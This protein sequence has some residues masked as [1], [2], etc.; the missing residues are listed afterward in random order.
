M[1][2]MWTRMPSTQILMP[3]TTI[4]TMILTLQ[5]RLK[6]STIR[7]HS[8]RTLTLPLVLKSSLQDNMLQQ[9]LPLPPQLQRFLEMTRP[10]RACM[11]LAMMETLSCTL[12]SQLCRNHLCLST[13]CTRSSVGTAMETLSVNVGSHSF[14]ISEPCLSTGS[15][16]SIFLP[17][18]VRLQLERKTRQ[19]C[20]RENISLTSS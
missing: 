1:R 8:H 3:T 11:L 5:L 20:V 12:V 17:F 19:S 16:D 9:P 6:I 10:T 2:N 18:H 14:T 7:C 4:T 15:L 13:I